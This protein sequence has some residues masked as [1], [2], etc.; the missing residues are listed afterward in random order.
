MVCDQVR[1]TKSAITVSLGTSSDLI[2]FIAK[3][4]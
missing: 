1:L 2:D 3:T 4:Q